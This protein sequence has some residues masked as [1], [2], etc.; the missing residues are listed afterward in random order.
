MTSLLITPGA[1]TVHVKT[2]LRERP[3]VGSCRPRSLVHFPALPVPALQSLSSALCGTSVKCRRQESTPCND[4]LPLCWVEFSAKGQRLIPV[5]A[6][7]RWAVTTSDDQREPGPQEAPGGPRGG[8][9]RL[10]SSCRPRFSVSSQTLRK[11]WQSGTEA[12]PRA[13]A[14]PPTCESQ[15]GAGRIQIPGP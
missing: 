6:L 4:L 5:A 15:F 1:V 11:A 9:H 13:Q 12:V 7:T 3:W 2:G 14:W 8:L 10:S